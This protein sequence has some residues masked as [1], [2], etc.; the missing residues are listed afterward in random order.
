MM[1]NKKMLDAINEQIKFE[2]YSAN[3]YLAMSAY[4]ESK[5]F[6]GMAEW[7]RVQYEEETLHVLKLYDY[8]K[9]RGGK[10]AIKAIDAPPCEFGT[11]NETFAEVL[12]HE[13]LVTSGIHKLYQ[14]AIEENDFAAQIF[15]QWFINEQIEEEES[16]SDVLNKLQ[17]VGDKT[18]GLLYLDKEL[19]AR[20]FVQ[21]DE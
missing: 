20:Q 4:I 9:S 8:V 18:A 13:Q 1:M 17:L 14:V 6:K 11:P 16:A 19:G 2:M 10:V 3:L 12:K 21:A 5:G 15:L 7:L